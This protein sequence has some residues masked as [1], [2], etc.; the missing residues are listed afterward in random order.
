MKTWTWSQAWSRTK[1]LWHARPGWLG[2]SGVKRLWQARPAWLASFEALRKRVVDIAVVAVGI[3][4][5]VGVVQQATD[6]A[7]VMDPISVPNQL[8]ELGYTSDVIAARLVDRAREI[9]RQTNAGPDRSGAAAA[10]GASPLMNVS[11]PGSGVSLAIVVDTARRLVGLPARRV[12]GEIVV[13]GTPEKTTYSLRVRI[14]GPQ[15]GAL[16][17]APKTSIDDVVEDGA[18]LLTHL[19]R[20]CALAG[21]L[22][23]EWNKEGARQLVDRCFADPSRR[24]LD[25]AHNLRG[26]RLFDEG[27][28]EAAIEEYKAAVRITPGYHNAL[29]SWAGALHR[30]G[31]LEGF[32]RK[33]DEARAALPPT[34]FSYAREGDILCRNGNETAGG[35]AYQKA[36]ALDPTAIAGGPDAW[37]KKCREL[38][39]VQPPK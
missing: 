27:H 21:L 10:S 39:V 31:D 22:Y 35:A 7:P 34:G 18:R 36:Y 33:L 23:I 1:A 5:L 4:L 19:L 2:W 13:S 20:P 9:E 30:K 28:W 32:N 6:S 15:P 16:T 17:S 3:V 26:L 37:A 25:W 38:R 29:V 24:D 12:G 11:V 8:A 14:S